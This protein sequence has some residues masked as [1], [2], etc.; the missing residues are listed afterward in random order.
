MNSL[1]A[2]IIC[3]FHEYHP[4]FLFSLT[5]TILNL[6]SFSW[7]FCRIAI[8]LFCKELQFYPSRERCRSSPDDPAHLRFLPHRQLRAQRP[9]PEGRAH[10]GGCEIPSQPRAHHGG[11]MRGTASLAQAAAS[12]VRS[13]DVFC[14]FSMKRY[15]ITEKLWGPIVISVTVQK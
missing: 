10:L 13:P 4:N 5:I 1:I 7:H 9:S 12:F 11:C 15:S 8:N 6:H 3:G 2:T 14:F